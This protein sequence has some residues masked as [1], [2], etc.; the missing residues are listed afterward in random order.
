MCTNVRLSAISYQ[1]SAISYQLSAISYQ[2]STRRQGS[3]GNRA[4]LRF[5]YLRVVAFLRTQA[6]GQYQ[7]E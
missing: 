7:N 3:R 6:Y 5:A 1:L 4:V 2:L